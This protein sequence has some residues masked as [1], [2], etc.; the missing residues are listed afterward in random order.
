MVTTLKLDAALG[1]QSELNDLY[2]KAIEE[3]ERMLRVSNCQIINI[4]SSDSKKG[5]L[6]RKQVVTIV[7]TGTSSTI[8]STYTVYP[9]RGVF[10]GITGV[11]FHNY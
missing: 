2:A 3:F 6:S 9:K 7:W 11:E 4:S 5:L 8:K 10:G 1:S